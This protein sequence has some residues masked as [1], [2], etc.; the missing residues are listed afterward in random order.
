MLLHSDT[1]S[2]FRAN[3]SLFLLLNDVCLAEKQQIPILYSL[4]CPDR[5]LEP[6][7]NH[8]RGEHREHANDW[9]TDAVTKTGIHEC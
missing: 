8:T 6:T 4:V 2:G 1:L 3:L 5:G 9:V 7:I